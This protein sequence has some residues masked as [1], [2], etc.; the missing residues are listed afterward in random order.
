MDISQLFVLNTPAFENVEYIRG[1][2][3]LEEL[4]FN[5]VDVITEHRLRVLKPENSTMQRLYLS[6]NAINFTGNKNNCQELKNLKI[7]DI[8]NLQ[9]NEF[10]N[11]FLRG[12]NNLNFLNIS[13]SNIEH[14]E[15]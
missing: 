9:N 3:H 2:N 13:F 14:F 5:D 15:A 4:F 6:E 11:D 10:P 8:S 7:L 1:F 12:C